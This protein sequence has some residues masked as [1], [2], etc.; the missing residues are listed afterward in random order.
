MDI[1]KAWSDLDRSQIA[2]GLKPGMD[3]IGTVLYAI[4]NA[5]MCEFQPQ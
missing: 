3:Y 2:G 5:E 1:V 4:I